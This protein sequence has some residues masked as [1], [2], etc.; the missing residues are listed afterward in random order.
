MHKLVERL[1]F[2]HTAKKDLTAAL[3]LH[4]VND[5]ETEIKGFCR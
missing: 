1:F 5:I 4:T 2:P 3:T